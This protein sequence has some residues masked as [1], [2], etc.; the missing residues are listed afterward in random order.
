MLGAL[1]LFVAGCG[2][3]NTGGTVSPAMFFL[4]NDTTPAIGTPVV[5]SIPSTPAKEFAYVK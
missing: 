3:I 2:G 5:P 4:K 1:A